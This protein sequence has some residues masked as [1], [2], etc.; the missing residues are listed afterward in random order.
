MLSGRYEAHGDV[1]GAR[2]QDESELIYGHI[3][4]FESVGSIDMVPDIE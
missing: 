2:N 3:V 4:V 1:Y